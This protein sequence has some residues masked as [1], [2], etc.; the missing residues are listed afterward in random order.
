MQNPPNE[1][2]QFLRW[3]CRE[4][5]LEEI[6]GDLTEVFKKQYE[7]SPRKAKWKFTWSVIK[8]F[9]PEFIK[10]FRNSYQP[11]SY[12]MYKSYFK[13][14]WRNLLKNKGYSFI[15]IGGLALGMTVA[16]LIGLWMHDELTF[17]SYHPN[18]DRIAQVMRHELFNGEIQTIG[19]PSGGPGRGVKQCLW[20]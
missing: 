19:I 11:D 12:G 9:R 8:Y 7:N 16:M 5:Y 18:H 2:L 15:N 17:D 20:R 10:S 13:I 6:E 4:D 1:P 14:G 3:F